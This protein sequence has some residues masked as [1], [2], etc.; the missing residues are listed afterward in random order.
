MQGQNCTTLAERD[1]TRSS[2]GLELRSRRR[3][4]GSLKLKRDLKRR[5]PPGFQ[6]TAMSVVRDLWPV[7]ATYCNDDWCTTYLPTARAHM[8]DCRGMKLSSWNG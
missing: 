2:A 1:L 3:Q 4:Q 5:R 7:A 6:S 8:A